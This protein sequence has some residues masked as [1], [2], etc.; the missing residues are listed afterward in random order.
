MFG[1]GGLG[2]LDSGTAVAIPGSL[3]STDM[4]MVRG[5]RHGHTIS[6]VAPRRA[7]GQPEGAVQAGPVCR[8]R[9][10]GRA[11][12]GDAATATQVGVTLARRYAGLQGPRLRRIPRAPRR[13]P[14][15]RG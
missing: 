6:E 7:R 13:R 15:R 4:T 11:A 8:P 14:R 5:E 12:H 1:R 10:Q 9:A 2:S 3:L